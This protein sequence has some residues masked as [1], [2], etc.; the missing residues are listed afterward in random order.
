MDSARPTTRLTIE[1]ETLSSDAP[2]AEVLR[3]DIE[4]LRAGLKYQGKVWADLVKEQTGNT[5]VEVAT[6][7]QLL[8]LKSHLRSLAG[9]Q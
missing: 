6:D 1:T 4:A 3:E 7:A 8:A 9:A 5:L 2:P